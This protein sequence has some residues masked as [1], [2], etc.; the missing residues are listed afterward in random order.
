M[1]RLEY[2][3]VE[4]TD[5]AVLVPE[6][7]SAKQVEGLILAEADELASTFAVARLILD[8]EA[9]GAEFVDLAASPLGRDMAN[10]VEV[11]DGDDRVLKLIRITW[12]F[13]IETEVA[14]GTSLE[15]FSSSMTWRPDFYSD[16]D[17]VDVLASNCVSFTESLAWSESEP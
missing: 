15:D 9:A 3:S 11:E 6:G 8:V 17:E 16:D 7:L 13:R 12:R 5:H 1:P 10:E 4:V 2:S 14:A